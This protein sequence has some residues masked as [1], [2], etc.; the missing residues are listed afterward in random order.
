MHHSPIGGATEQN[1]FCAED[2]GLTQADTTA[3]VQA[4]AETMRQVNAAI[5]SH[6]GFSTR[7]MSSYAVHAIDDPALDPRP[8]A[9]CNAFLR[10]YCRPENPNLKRVFI[11]EWTRKSMHDISPAPAVMQDLARFLLVRGPYAYIGWQWVGCRDS[12]ERPPALEHD[13]GVPV[14]A[15]CREVS[16]GV[17]ERRWTSG[18][19]RM[20]CNTWSATLPS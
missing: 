18:L 15:V 14:E 5:L 12:Y 17:F 16:Q 6:G 2:T 9:R 3:M 19:V 7:M 8:P 13:Y 1:P 20:D 4:L 10:E 11:Y